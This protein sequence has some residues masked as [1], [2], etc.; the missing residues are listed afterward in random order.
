MGLLVP[1]NCI[2]RNTLQWYW[3]Y[4]LLLVIF[5]NSFI[6]MSH[7][8]PLY[9]YTAFIYLWIGTF[10]CFYLLGSVNNVMNFCVQNLSVCRFSIFLG[11]YLRVE[12]ASLSEMSVQILCSF[13]DWVVFLLLSCKNSLYIL[14]TCLLCDVLFTN[15]FFPCCQGN[16]GMLDVLFFSNPSEWVLV[17]ADRIMGS[18]ASIFVQE[19]EVKEKRNR[20]L[21]YYAGQS[22]GERSK[23]FLF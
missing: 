14:V 21:S 18:L 17:S 2:F 3:L 10:S 8:I 16:R 5:L 4:S 6:L 7:N 23:L 15:N 11:L 13:L 12:L 1:Y 9:E 22:G 20:R 19:W